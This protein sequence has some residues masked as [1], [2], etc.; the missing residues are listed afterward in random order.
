MMQAWGWDAL[1]K[2]GC[3]ILEH[4]QKDRAKESSGS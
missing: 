2:K 3:E 1:V 4:D